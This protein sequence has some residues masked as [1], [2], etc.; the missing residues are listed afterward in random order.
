M[1]NDSNEAEDSA[2]WT[3]VI[4]ALVVYLT[5]IAAVKAYG[6]WRAREPA[7]DRSLGID[8]AT[9]FVT[10]G[11]AVLFFIALVLQQRELAQHRR[12]LR[13]NVY[14]VKRMVGEMRL[15]RLNS[16]VREAIS[17]WEA[18]RSAMR[19]SVHALF[20]YGIDLDCRTSIRREINGLV[21]RRMVGSKQDRDRVFATYR[22]QVTDEEGGSKLR[23]D[24]ENDLRLDFIV[25]LCQIGAYDSIDVPAANAIGHIHAV[26]PMFTNMIQIARHCDAVATGTAARNADEVLS[27]RRHYDAWSRLRGIV[28]VD[29]GAL[30]TLRNVCVSSIFCIRDQL[31][32]HAHESLLEAELYIGATDVLGYLGLLPAEEQIKFIRTSEKDRHREFRLEK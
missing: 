9:L 1:S 31:K 28:D 19:E 8:A 26:L 7:I 13:A 17:E 25:E 14:E 5:I 3:I 24:E 29:R 16:E 2:P 30:T 18:K 11:A 27:R 23:N 6:Y 20:R 32:L 15:D 22:R 4:A 10:G 21:R 12:E